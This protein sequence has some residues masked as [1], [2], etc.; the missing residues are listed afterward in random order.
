LV[1]SFIEI[2]GEEKTTEW[3]KGIVANL[4]R[5]P[6]GN[7]RDQAKAVV[8][9]EGDVAIMNTYYVGKMQISDP[10]EVKGREKIGVLFQIN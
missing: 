8:A 5:E 10:E 6:K 1:A 4:A 3:V 7:D 9:G 2:N